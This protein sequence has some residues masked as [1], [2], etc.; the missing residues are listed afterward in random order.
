M[1][2]QDPLGQLARIKRLE[3]PPFLLTRI[4]ARLAAAQERAPR[5]WTVAVLSLAV[6]LLLLNLSVLRGRS[7]APA[8]MEGTTSDLAAS[9]GLEP[10]NQLYQ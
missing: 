1:H 2:D 9:F 4:E 6:L 3:P 10:S 7:G 5:S 8:E